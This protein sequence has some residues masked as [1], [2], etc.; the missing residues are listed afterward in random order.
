MHPAGIMR[1]ATAAMVLVAGAALVPCSGA[2]G[3]TSA[4]ASADTASSTTGTVAPVPEHRIV[5][6]EVGT[7]PGRLVRRISARVLPA[8]D[9]GGEPGSSLVVLTALREASMDDARWQ[10]L[11]AAHEAEILLL[12]HRIERSAA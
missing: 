7:D 3:A 9:L 5:D 1:R 10:R 8:D 2:V 11:V 6:F 12:R 4:T